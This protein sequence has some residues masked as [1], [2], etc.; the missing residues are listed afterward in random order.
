MRIGGGGTGDSRH[1]VLL[2]RFYRQVA[3]R[4][5]ARLGAGYDVAADTH[6]STGRLGARPPSPGELL[7]GPRG[8]HVSIP[9]L[10]GDRD[11]DRAVAALYDQHYA[12]LVRLA[13]LLVGDARTAEEIVQDSFVALHASW[14]RP[15]DRDWALSCLRQSVLHRSR[16][17]GRRRTTAEPKAPGRATAGPAGPRPTSPGPGRP[18]VISALRELPA[19]Q[20]EAVVMRYYAGLSEARVAEAMA[21]TRRAAREHTE[22]GMVALRAMLDAAMTPAGQVRPG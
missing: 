22:R 19:R 3:K 8:K 5:A 2:Y 13:S 6:R 16:S 9:G 10:R 18:A 4:H 1:D 17:A 7:T 14:R 21:I 12:G 11:A 20:R 15:R